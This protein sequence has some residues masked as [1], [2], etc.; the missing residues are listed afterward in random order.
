MLY[1]VGCIERQREGKAGE[2]GKNVGI[3]LKY[4]YVP[5]S[6][7]LVLDSAIIASIAEMYSSIFARTTSSARSRAAAL[8]RRTRCMTVVNCPFFGWLASFKAVN[9]Q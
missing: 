9:Y 7:G 6:S 4:N 2:G 5:P 3:T 1:S 8:S